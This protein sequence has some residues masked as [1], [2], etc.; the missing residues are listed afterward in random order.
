M[1]FTACG[2]PSDNCADGVVMLMSYSSVVN[3]VL[4]LWGVGPILRMG[5]EFRD[6]KS[7]DVKCQQ[8]DTP[9]I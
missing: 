1:W 4:V 2:A 9:G 6:K 3:L 7:V 5:I 8:S